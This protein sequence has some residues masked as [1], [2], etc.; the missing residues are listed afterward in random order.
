MKVLFFIYALDQG[1]GAERVTANLANHWAKKGWEVTVTTVTARADDWHP[2]DPEIRHIAINLG[3]P[4][5]GMADAIAQNIKRVKTL[6]HTL[7]TVRP[8]VA[9]AMMSAASA[10]L[11]VAAWGLPNLVSLGAIRSHPACRPTKAVWK[12]IEALAFG[13]LSAVVAQTKTTAAWLAANTASRRIEVIP[14]PIVW[15]LPQSEPNIQPDGVCK[16]NRNVLLAAGRLVPLKRYDLL[17]DVFAALA[18]EHENWDLVIAGDG[19]E[20]QKL[21]SQICE[22]GIGSRVFLPG[23]AGNLSDWYE[24]ADLFVMTS[25]FEGFPN[26]LA[27]ALAHGTPAVSFDCDAGP[28][29]IICHGQDGL[30]VPA[31]DMPALTQAL[32]RLMR[33]DSMRG[34][35]A[36]A[37][38]QQRDRF[39][40][41]SV[42]RIW[43]DLFADLLNSKSGQGCTFAKGLAH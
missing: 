43:E 19:P 18:R 36:V 14:N 27:E 28:R 31:G 39:A 26:A 3:R 1:G 32:D 9:V 20:R 10:T 12:G 23:F 21:R 6:R 42:S 29:D 40:I 24:R 25:I 35:F 33:Y 8:D 30:L 41:Q 5:R 17:I 2:L 34:S 11:A 15:P 13:H 16:T 7:L 37:A 22:R 4:S 38:R